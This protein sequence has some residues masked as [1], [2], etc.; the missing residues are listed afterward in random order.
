[1]LRRSRLTD[2]G[3]MAISTAINTKSSQTI[4]EVA[5]RPGRYDGS[6]R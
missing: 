3:S 4:E 2:L 6:G 1:M 5:R